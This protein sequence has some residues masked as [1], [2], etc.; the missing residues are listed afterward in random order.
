MA[1]TVENCCAVMPRSSVM[2]PILAMATLLPVHQHPGP[3]GP[4]HSS[5]ASVHTFGPSLPLLAASLT[6]KKVENVQADKRRHEQDINLACS[7]FIQLG[8]LAVAQPRQ[9]R[10][11]VDFEP[12]VVGSG[13]AVCA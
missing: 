12:I 8:N 4:T 6:V 9:T 7:R 11:G 3:A 10:R 2:P 13:P 1:T 5:T